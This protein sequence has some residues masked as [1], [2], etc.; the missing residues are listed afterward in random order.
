VSFATEK[1]CPDRDTLVARMPVRVLEGVPDEEVRRLLSVA[2]RRTFAR[3]EVVFHQGDPAEAMHVVWNGRFAVRIRSAIGD[4]TTV[5]ILGPG[6][7][8]GELALLDDDSERSATVVALERA[9]TRSIARSDFTKL[10]SEQPQVNELLLRLL[11]RR[12]RRTND[13]L[14]EA[15]YL[16]AD[17]RVLRRIRELAELYGPGEGAGVIPLTQEEIAELAGTSRAT[18]NRVLRAEER[19]GSIELTRGRTTVLDPHRLGSSARS[20]PGM[21][22]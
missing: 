11:A 4:A 6:E 16:P 9:E 3:N 8:F 15:L 12:L 10:R 21:V 19:A 22:S 5:A 20:E 1:N 18:V 7:A 2:R 13:L 17:V 14:A